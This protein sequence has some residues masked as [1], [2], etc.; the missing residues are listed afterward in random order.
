[1]KR[2][3]KKKKG[4]S[5]QR[6]RGRKQD[7]FFGH[8]QNEKK[9]LRHNLAIQAS[10]NGW[11]GTD[12]GGGGKGWY[13]MNAASAKTENSTGGGGRAYYITLINFPSKRA[14]N[15]IRSTTRRGHC[16]GGKRGTHM[17]LIMGASSTTGLFGGR[18]SWE[19]YKKGE[20]WVRQGQKVA[21]SMKL[22]MDLRY[23]IAVLKDEEASEQTLV[24]AHERVSCEG[25]LI[26]L[27]VQT[28]TVV[29]GGD[30]KNEQKKN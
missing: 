14:I 15:A 3:K 29:K 6:E 10:G 13:R 8:D 19:L 22:L 21:K 7:F 16:T 17:R 24:A 25:K 11:G 1:V 30:F 23:K 18:G 26:I 9:S 5:N 27:G 28:V 12:W 4:R 20:A 2:L